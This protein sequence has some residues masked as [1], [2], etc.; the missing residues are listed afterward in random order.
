MFATIQTSGSGFIVG[1][2]RVRRG[3]RQFISNKTGRMVRKSMEERRVMTRTANE[4]AQFLGCAIEGDG[5]TIV[6][7]VAAPA[8]ARAPD[9]I[10]VETRRHPDAAA[11]SAA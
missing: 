7:G 2:K 11:A 1:G 3:A 8:S 4:L 9:L 5:S 6:S 10:Y